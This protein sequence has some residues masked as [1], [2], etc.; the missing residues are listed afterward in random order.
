[1]TFDVNGQVKNNRDDIK[2]LNRELE[3]VRIAVARHD[4][5]I[6]R[7]RKNIHSLEGLVAI[8]NGRIDEIE[9]K[10]NAQKAVQKSA[11]KWRD[12]LFKLITYGIIPLLMFIFGGGLYELLKK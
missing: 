3:E 9:K 8:D 10:I 6:A 7:A 12:W 4:E 2:Q 5:Q 11:D 1:M